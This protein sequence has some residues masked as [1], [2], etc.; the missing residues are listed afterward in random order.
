[1]NVS[2]EEILTL[3]SAIVDAYRIIGS[4]LYVTKYTE[5][6]MQKAATPTYVVTSETAALLNSDPNILNKAKE[7]LRDRYRNIDGTN[8]RNQYIN[9]AIDA[10]EGSQEKLEE[11]MQTSIENSQSSRQKYLDSLSGGT[12]EE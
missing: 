8:I 9:K 3:S 1:M 6:G 5:A 7:A 11:K 12:V 10:T 4:K 2:E